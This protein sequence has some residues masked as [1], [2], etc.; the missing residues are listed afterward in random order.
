VLLTT[1]KYLIYD[2]CIDIVFT[3][4]RKNFSKKYT[5][6]TSDMI[7]MRIKGATLNT[8]FTTTV[9]KVIGNTTNI[10][11]DMIVVEYNRSQIQTAFGV[12]YNESVCLCIDVYVEGAFYTTYP[13]FE[14]VDVYL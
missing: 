5:L 9:G 6:L 8:P 13:E 3:G 14:L 10:V 12:D 1:L 7:G 11:T 4:L 2:R